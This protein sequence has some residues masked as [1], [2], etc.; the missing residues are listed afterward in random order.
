MT[1]K[2]NNL[3]FIFTPQCVLVKDLDHYIEKKTSKKLVVEKVGISQRKL[4][5]NLSKI[6]FQ[7]LKIFKTFT[8]VVVAS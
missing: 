3:V 7:L 5:D 6:I 2:I 1:V 8:N 4:R